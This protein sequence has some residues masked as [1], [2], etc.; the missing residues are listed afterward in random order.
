MLFLFSCT[1][2]NH[3]RLQLLGVDMFDEMAKKKK[4]KKKKELFPLCAK[5][6]VFYLTGIY[7][8]ENFRP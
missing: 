7:C 5:E 6:Q 3:A 1:N 2:F 8:C 4:K